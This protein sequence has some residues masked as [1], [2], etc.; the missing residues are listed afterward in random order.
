M[1]TIKMDKFVE[2]VAKNAGISYPSPSK[3]LTWSRMFLILSC[4]T[5]QTAS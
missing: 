2:L 3:L 4:H 5:P 1:S